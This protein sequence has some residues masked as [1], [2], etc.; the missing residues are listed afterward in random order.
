MDYYKLLGIGKNATPEEIKK[1]FREKAK[2][3]H[4]DINPEG[5]ENFK[6]I[7]KAYETLINPEKRKI[8][9]KSLQSIGIKSKL[10]NLIK[11]IVK[12]ENPINGSNIVIKEYVTFEE[13]F[14]GFKYTVDFFRDSICTACNGTGIGE[15][16]ILKRCPK[17]NGKESIKTPLIEIPCPYCKG[18]GFIV[19]NP[20]YECKGKGLKKEKVRKTIDV[21][22]FSYEKFTLVFEGEGNAG[23][24]NGKNGN[25]YITFRLK[26]H[27]FYKKKGLDLHANIYISKEKKYQENTVKIKNLKGE[28]LKVKIPPNCENQVLKISGEGFKGKENKRGNIYLQ[29]HYV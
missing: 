26:Q 8:Y 10:E 22:P 12:K 15:N 2:K 17:C 9:D 5:S 29:V 7:T 13:A 4:P 27:P 24:N 19:Y 21:P 11:K 23:K 25:L 1:A 6:E 28:I 20:C 14:N 16:S 3:Y 18:K